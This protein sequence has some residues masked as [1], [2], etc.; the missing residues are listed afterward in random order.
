MGCMYKLWSKSSETVP[1]ANKWREAR[2]CTSNSSEWVCC[3][4]SCCKHQDLYYMRFGDHMHVHICDWSQTFKFSVKLWKLVT[5]SLEMLHEDNPWKCPRNWAQKTLPSSLLQCRR[6]AEM[7]HRSPFPIKPGL[8][9]LRS[10]VNC[11]KN[12]CNRS[13]CW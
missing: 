5:V 6:L 3:M 13:W 10:R 2:T 8:T 12:A 11:H 1:M 7:L 9:S 4:M